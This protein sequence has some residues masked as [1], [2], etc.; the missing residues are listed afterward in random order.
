[1]TD[2]ENTTSATRT[3]RVI[4][5]VAFGIGVTFT[6][7]W[8]FISVSQLMGLIADQDIDAP[9]LVAIAAV[10]GPTLFSGPSSVSATE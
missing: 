1:M 6:S 9:L 7:L 10:A 4:T 8:A 2:T 5:I 3:V